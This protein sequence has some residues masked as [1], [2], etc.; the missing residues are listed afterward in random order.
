MTNA[1]S[2]S[3]C[4]GQQTELTTATVR[5]LILSDPVTGLRAVLR[6]C[7]EIERQSLGVRRVTWKGRD[8][9]IAWHLNFDQ[10]E[11]K[12]TPHVQVETPDDP[13]SKND[14]SLKML[15]DRVQ[16][17]LNGLPMHMDVPF[18]RIDLLEWVPEL[19]Q[20]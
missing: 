1:Y 7:R 15:A 3:Y 18:E 14:P 2:H 13:T 5:N 6:K 11:C 4:P 17:A 10:V 19:C 8:I 12:F 20:P 16:S 9:A